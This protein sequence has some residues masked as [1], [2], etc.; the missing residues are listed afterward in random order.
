MTW[1][2]SIGVAIVGLVVIGLA[3]IWAPT[4]RP[5]DAKMEPQRLVT[6]WRTFLD[7][8]ERAL[9]TGNHARAMRAWKDAETAALDSRRWEPLLEVGDAALRV[10][11]GTGSPARARLSARH[12]YRAALFRAR[13]QRSVDGVLRAADAFAR[14]GDRD[15]TE[16][17]LHAARKL[18][19][20]APDADLR[21]RVEL[22]AARIAA[23]VV[24]E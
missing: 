17:A 24:A 23:R 11:D 22:D 13:A 2:R 3:G 21:S 4:P 18:A 7:E 16:G 9:A 6:P 1:R 5:L 14:L 10:G 8:L 19:A 20:G 12:A 15:V